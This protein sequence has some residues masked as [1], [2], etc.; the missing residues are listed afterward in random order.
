M[1]ELA[2]R[3]HD[4]KIILHVR[5]RAYLSSA[6][7]RYHKSCYRSY[8]RDSSITKDK[9]HL[10]ETTDVVFEQFCTDV[11]AGNLYQ[12]QKVLCMSKLHEMYVECGKE[13]G[14]DLSTTKQT[15]KKK[16]VERFPG[17]HFLNTTRETE[18]NLFT[19]T[20]CPRQNT[21]NEPNESD[22]EL[23]YLEFETEQS[24]A[25][26][27]ANAQREM[28]MSAVHLKTVLQTHSAPLT[29]VW[30]PYATD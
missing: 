11:I 17:H 9:E 15:L 2:E 8:T 20:R 21:Y 4:E 3:R 25:G 22:N 29:E 14:I 28:Y 6:E 5:V 24:E 12:D 23:Q 1:L 19:F 16:L 13:H 27:L 30:P 26:F 7:V 18:V 10:K